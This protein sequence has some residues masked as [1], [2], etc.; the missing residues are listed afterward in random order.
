LAEGSNRRAFDTLEEGIIALLRRDP[1]VANREMA[2]ALGVSEATIASRIRSLAE[3]KLV[4]VTAQEDIRAMGF[5]LLV[6][7][8]VFVAGRPAEE[9]AADLA[10]FEQVGS[11]SITMTSPEII[12]QLL[13]RDRA[14]LM[15]VLEEEIAAVPGVSAVESL[16]VLSTVKFQSDYGELDSL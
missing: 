10:A 5:D 2:E 4:R 11:V 6:L 3:R 8:D 12:V 14:D 13:A 7:L 16:V 15:R 1:R 9:V